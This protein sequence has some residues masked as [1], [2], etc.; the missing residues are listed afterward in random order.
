MSTWLS[1]AKHRDLTNLGH[2][3]GKFAPF[4]GVVLHVNV[5][6]KKSQGTSPDW[7]A[8]GGGPDQ[9]CPNFQ[10]MRD[11]TIW[12]LLP[13]DVQPWTQ[14]A[15]NGNYASIETG[16]DP[17]EPLT[18]A[19]VRSCGLIIR[20]YHEKYGMP[21]R[22][23]NAPGQR[24]FGTH[25][26]GGQSWGGHSCPGSIRAKQRNDILA[27]ARG[28]TTEDPL[29]ADKLNSTV[30]GQIETIVS[31]QLDKRFPSYLLASDID[32]NGK[33]DKSKHSIDAIVHDQVADVVRQILREAGLLK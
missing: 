3:N 21:L 14:A 23:A 8:A 19:Q 33:T 32:D 26:M 31:R 25:S 15:G 16:G 24:G 12:Q 4:L 5:S 13:M 28:N 22:L 29:M 10:V 27:V 11:G 6:G 20:A 9:V 18:P 7:Y 30:V 1:G 17:D 2:H